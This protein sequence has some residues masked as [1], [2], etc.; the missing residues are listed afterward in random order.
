[1][2]RQYSREEPRSENSATTIEHA[3]A[4][5]ILPACLF[6]EASITRSSSRPVDLAE[7]MIDT[8]ID[9]TIEGMIEGMT[10]ATKAYWCQ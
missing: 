10:G 1:M 5:R 2:E 4:C 7:E 9:M 3:V 8:T 6:F